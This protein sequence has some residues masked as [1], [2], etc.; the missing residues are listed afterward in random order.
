[1]QG[2]ITGKRIELER[3][4]DLPSGSNVIVRIQPKL[5]TLEEKRQMVDLLCGTWAG[6]A[7]LAPIFAEIEHRR[8]ITAPREVGFNAAS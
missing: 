7:S 2:V 3:E 5:L 6:D 1:M 8:T 4:P